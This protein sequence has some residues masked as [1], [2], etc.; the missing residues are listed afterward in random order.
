MLPSLLMCVFPY[1]DLASTAGTEE[2][3]AL[4]SGN[5]C[6]LMSAAPFYV[7]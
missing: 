1:A 5:G 7:L 4:E 3:A 2:R 6:S